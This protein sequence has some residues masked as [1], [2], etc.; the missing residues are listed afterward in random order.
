VAG[1]LVEGSELVLPSVGTNRTRSG[2]ID[3]LIAMGADLEVQALRSVGVEP[4][5]D[6]V[7]HSAQLRGT[8]ISGELALRCLDELPVL[9]VAAA[10]AEGETVIADA[11]E[12]R[13]KESDRIARV[14]AGLRALHVEV[15]ERPDGLVIQGGRPHGPARVDASGDHRIAMAF[16][17]AALACEGGV[18]IEGADSIA[19][20]YPSFFQVI[21]DVSRVQ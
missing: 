16:S 6:L 15:E 11:A 19:S 3:A 1:S 5:A 18:V 2:V 12:L 21:E 10:F 13:V 14:A 8:E 17:V 4:R 7:V 20:S 9:A